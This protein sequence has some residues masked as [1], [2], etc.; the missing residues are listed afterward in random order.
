VPAEGKVLVK[1]CGNVVMTVES[2][3]PLGM[4]F[5]PLVVEWGLATQ[6]HIT[7]SPTLMVT[8]VGEKRSVGF[9]TITLVLAAKL[10]SEEAKHNKTAAATPGKVLNKDF[11][12]LLQM[13]V[14]RTRF[15][16]NNLFPSKV[17]VLE[18][19]ADEVDAVVV[20]WFVK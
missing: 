18:R 17:L 1:E 9:P 7:S 2:H 19:V 10:E 16:P 20:G 4:L 8:L 15:V 6:V 3:N 13:R 11:I 12:S 5:V 14:T